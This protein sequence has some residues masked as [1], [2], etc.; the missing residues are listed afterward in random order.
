MRR[1]PIWAR[2][3]CPSSTQ[4]DSKA[5]FLGG[6]DVDVSSNF[7]DCTTSKS[8]GFSPLR[9][10]ARVDPDLPEMRSADRLRVQSLSNN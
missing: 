5:Q 9:I 4:A 10:Y 6:L 2:S 7:T 1:A 3:D 8:D